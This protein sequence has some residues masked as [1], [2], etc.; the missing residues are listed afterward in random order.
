MTILYRPVGFKELRLIAD[1]GFRSF[2]PRL[3]E[4][5]FFYP[6]LSVEYARK[7][8]H[9]WNT[10]DEFSEYIG[11]VVQFEVDEAAIQRYPAQIA[12][13]SLHQE[14]Q[15]PAEELVEFNSNIIGT[16]KVIEKYIGE[17]AVGAESDDFLSKTKADEV[18]WIQEL[19]IGSDWNIKHCDFLLDPE[20]MQ[21]F[22]DLAA[23]YINR[24]SMS[25]KWNKKIDYAGVRFSF[26]MAYHGNDL[27]VWSAGL[28][29]EA[30]IPYGNFLKPETK[31]NLSREFK[32]VCDLMIASELPTGRACGLP[33]GPSGIKEF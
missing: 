9:D 33:F 4:Q 6:V 8:A 12:G 27:S 19:S 3:P 29:L 26:G 22:E 20:I 10:K 13:G 28:S 31:E 11:C 32:R 25:S 18:E 24:H 5:P 21:S 17:K 15:I 16:I 30:S 14:L 23:S 7:I 1:S 2:P